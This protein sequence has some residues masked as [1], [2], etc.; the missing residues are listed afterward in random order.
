MLKQVKAVRHQIVRDRLHI[1]FFFFKSAYSESLKRNIQLVQLKTECFETKWR[2]KC[3]VPRRVYVLQ[4]QNNLPAATA[5][6][7]TR[8]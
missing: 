1:I 7:N 3:N 2:L 8:L 6:T 4:G 5:H